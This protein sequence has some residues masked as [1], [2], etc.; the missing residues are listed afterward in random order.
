MAATSVKK[1]ENSQAWIPE[2]GK[3]QE[4]AADTDYTGIY[5][6][7]ACAVGSIYLCA[8]C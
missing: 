7:S 6:N 2:V 5:H 4:G 3:K 1:V 8:I